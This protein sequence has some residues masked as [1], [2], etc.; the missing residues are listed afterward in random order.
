MSKDEKSISIKIKNQTKLWTDTAFH[1]GLSH[2]S[3]W[4]DKV[5]I[6]DKVQST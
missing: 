4:G 2:Y 1:K 3:T 6:C 5:S